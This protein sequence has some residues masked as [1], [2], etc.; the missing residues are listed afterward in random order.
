M[1]TK[2]QR[3][4]VSVGLFRHGL[5]LGDQYPRLAFTRPSLVLGE[6]GIATEYTS[7]IISGDPREIHPLP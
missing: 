6:G 4:D 2:N 5:A 1:R 7:H 3:Y